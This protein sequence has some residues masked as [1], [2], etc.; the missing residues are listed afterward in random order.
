M[1]DFAGVVSLKMGC[2]VIRITPVAAF[3]VLWQGKCRRFGKIEQ[4]RQPDAHRADGTAVESVRQFSPSL[5]RYER[6]KDGV[7]KT[8][9]FR[10]FFFGGAKERFHASRRVRRTNRRKWRKMIFRDL[11]S[12][13]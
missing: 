12:V 10:K 1:G 3:S 8:T 11:F 7:A 2:K 4:V 9:L 13:R 5:A 6:Y